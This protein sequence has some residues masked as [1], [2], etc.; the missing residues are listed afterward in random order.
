M[1]PT[2]LGGSGAENLNGTVAADNLLGRLGVGLVFVDAGDDVVVYNPMDSFGGGTGLDTLSLDT[3]IFLTG[4]AGGANLFAGFKKSG[5]M[6]GFSNEL[7]NFG[8]LAGVLDKIAIAGDAFD[9]VILNGQDLSKMHC[10]PA[11]HRHLH[12]KWILLVM[13]TAIFRLLICQAQ[14]IFC[15]MHC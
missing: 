9:K 6:N 13:A 4:I 2:V 1:D 5:M 11:L 14:H 15:S 10:L 7:N 12:L 3:T 8:I